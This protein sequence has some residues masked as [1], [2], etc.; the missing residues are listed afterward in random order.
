MKFKYDIDACE[1]AKAETGKGRCGPTAVC[2]TPK[3]YQVVVFEQSWTNTLEVRSIQPLSAHRRD[4][5][6]DND[7][8]LLVVSYPLLGGWNPVAVDKVDTER[9]TK[10]LK[11]SASYR[12]GSTVK[13]VCYFSVLGLQTQVVRGYNYQYD[14]YGCE[15]T[16]AEA[17]NGKCAAASQCATPARF[18]VTLSQDPST[19][20]VSVTSVDEGRAVAPVTGGWAPMSVEKQDADRLA[21]VLKTTAS[22]K[23]NSSRR[24]CYVAVLGL[25]RQVVAGIKYRYDV[26]A[27]PVASAEAGNGKCPASTSCAPYRFKITVLEQSWTNTLDI[28]GL[29]Q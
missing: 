20:A 17:G 11:S 8:D 12:A 4:A 5:A 10:T 27:C 26:Y 14:I 23:T 1:V 21:T 9:L 2:K 6:M 7:D 16:S 28:V 13:R 24:L 18:K 25:E 3:R 29:T 15:V 22:Y 19:N